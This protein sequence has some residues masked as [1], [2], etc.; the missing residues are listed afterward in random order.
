MRKKVTGEKVEKSSFFESARQR[1]L[2]YVKNPGKLNSLLDQA[3]KKTENRRGQ[4][5][6]VWDSLQACLRLLRAWANG[7]YREIPWDS[8][9]AIAAAVIYFV[10]PL[11]MIPDFIL[12]LGLIDD[13]ALFTWIL[14]SVRNDVDRFI[15]WEQ[16][17]APQNHDETHEPEPKGS[18]SIEKNEAPKA[19]GPIDPESG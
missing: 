12:S 16:G 9:V 1:A 11:D 13:V 18:V 8:L 3:W 5:A 10:M 6:E 2:D 14:S 15:E 17:D 19:S 7:S 4:L